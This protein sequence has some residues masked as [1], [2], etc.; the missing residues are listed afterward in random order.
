MIRASAFLTRVAKSTDRAVQQRVVVASQ[1]E[2]N[3]GECAEPIRVVNQDILNMVVVPRDGQSVV[4]C[5]RQSEVDNGVMI[6]SNGR[7]SSLARLWAVTVVD[8]Y[9]L[10][11]QETEAHELCC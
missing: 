9:R 5:G 6:A 7:L 8:R 4:V 11:A 2:R 3:V 1:L 10:C